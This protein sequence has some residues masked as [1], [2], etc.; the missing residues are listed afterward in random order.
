MRLTS[1]GTFQSGMKACQAHSEHLY[2]PAVVTS[3]WQ[4]NPSERDW[5]LQRHFD[6]CLLDAIL[7]VQAGG[8]GDGATAEVPL[9]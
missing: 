9:Y 1:A 5:T 3:G 6:G 7:S 8:P 2:V 4:L